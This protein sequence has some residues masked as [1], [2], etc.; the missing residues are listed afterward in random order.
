MLRLPIFCSMRTKV[1]S[2]ENLPNDLFECNCGYFENKNDDG[3]YATQ[4]ENRN[5]TNG[6][7]YDDYDDA[8][9]MGV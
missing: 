3:H 8:S 4:H 2:P 6:K 5:K 7:N 9:M 1:S